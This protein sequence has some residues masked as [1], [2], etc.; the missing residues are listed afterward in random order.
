M[1]DLPGLEIIIEHTLKFDNETHL[2]EYCKTLTDLKINFYLKRT[3]KTG[4]KPLFPNSR[5]RCEFTFYSE[6]DYL[7]ALIVK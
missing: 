4:F 2:N 5:L 3:F 1:C 6:S 7:A